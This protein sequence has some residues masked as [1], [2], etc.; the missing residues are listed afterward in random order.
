[1]ANNLNS[2]LKKLREETGSESFKT[3]KYGEVHSWVSTGSYALNRIISGSIYKGIPSGKVIILA[4]ENSVGKSLIA[5]HI[6]A[7]ALKS[8]YDYVFYFDSEGGA[9]REFFENVGCDPDLIEH[10]LVENVEDAQLQIMRVYNLIKEYK[11][12]NPDKDMKFLCVLDSLGGLV[13]EKTMTDADK[14]KVVSEMGG[15]AKK[16]NTLMK[17]ITVPA[18][19]TDTSMIVLNHVYDDPSAMFTNK[20]KNQSGGKGLQYMASI[21]IQCARNLE[22]DGDKNSE[23]FYSGTN[24]T[25]FTVKNRMC[26]PSLEA[27]IYLDFKKGF[28]NPYDGLFDE[29]VRG[30]FI[31]CPAQGYYTVPTCSDPEKKW[32]KAQIEANKE[33]WNTFIDKFNEWSLNDLKYSKLAQEAIEADNKSD[34]DEEKI[35]DNN[36]EIDNE[37][38]S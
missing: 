12:K 4:G 9:L 11:E 32:R 22:K 6:M 5:A 25:F 29:A 23:G 15:R 34:E 26:R 37:L 19:K 33:I 24:L 35:T 16:I 10:I 1:M 2:F 36:N 14:G 27:K 3:S 18:I 8:G 13:A 21:T 31:L 17:A 38:N 7:N 28:I 30:G 20:I